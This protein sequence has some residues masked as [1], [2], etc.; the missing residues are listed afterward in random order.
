MQNFL[1]ILFLFSV[2]SFFGWILELLFRRFLSKN[3]PERKWINPGFLVGPCL[4][5][6]GFSLIVLYL[7]SKIDLW[8][9]ENPIVKQ[10][11]LF[12]VMSI[13]ITFLEFIA[14]LIFIKGMKIKL[15]DYSD[16][17]GNIKGII[18]PQFSF[19]WIV[20]SALYYFLINPRIIS[21]VFW[22]TNHL[23]FSFFTGVYYGILIIDIIY[24]F[25]LVSKVKKFAK[26]NQM[27]IIMEKFKQN[28]RKIN[29][30]QK[31]KIHFLFSLRSDKENLTELLKKYLERF[32][33]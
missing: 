29:E 7:L 16:C 22:F 23:V 2:G 1:V 26:E 28:I 18:C 14:G 24:S 21:W 11:S 17:F 20:L 4:P 9:I 31:Q 8:F 33:K 5:L 12:V 15:W 19:Y 13:C 32:K 3:N 27:I 25:Q 10:I 30:E 6:Y